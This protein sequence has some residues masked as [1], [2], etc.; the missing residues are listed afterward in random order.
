MAAHRKRGRSERHSERA[1]GK[2]ETD[3]G[4]ATL[5]PARKGSLSLPGHAAQMRCL[6]VGCCCWWPLAG[7][8]AL[9][10]YWGCVTTL[11]ESS[12][13]LWAA[14]RKATADQH[15]PVLA[16]GNLGRFAASAPPVAAHRCRTGARRGVGA[17]L[18]ACAQRTFRRAIKSGRYIR[19]HAAPGP[20]GHCAK[21]P[22]FALLSFRLPERKKKK[23]RLHTAGP[24][25]GLAGEA[26]TRLIISIC[27]SAQ[28]SSLLHHALLASTMRR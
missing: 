25:Y 2:K 28:S 17:L 11:D 19:N 23:A 9:D 10:Q 24:S 12:R 22:P 15:R 27:D 21:P 7:S 8:P 16:R 1:R 20:A 5:P 6:F 13:A 14:V 3:R 4:R 26:S 18:C